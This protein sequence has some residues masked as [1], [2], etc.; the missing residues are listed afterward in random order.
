MATWEWYV[1]NAGQFARATGWTARAIERIGLDSAAEAVFLRGLESI[2]A[3]MRRLR[4]K[5]AAE[6]RA[7]K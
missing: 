5:A 3:M 2:D 4:A 1:K 6:A 7:G